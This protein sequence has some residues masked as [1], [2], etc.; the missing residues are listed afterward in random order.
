MLTDAEHVVARPRP[1][2]GKRLLRLA[3]K[4]HLDDSILDLDPEHWPDEDL[5]QE[6]LEL[7]SSAMSATSMTEASQQMRESGTDEQKML[8]GAIEKW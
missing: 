3:R 8:M 6:P 7:A 1:A 2:V 5:T 4:H